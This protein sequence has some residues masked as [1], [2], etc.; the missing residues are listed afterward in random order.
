MV[1]WSMTLIGGKDHGA[2]GVDDLG[3]SM[4]ALGL[5]VAGESGCN[6]ERQ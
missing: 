6:T 3:F 1:P 4:A 2:D 5:A